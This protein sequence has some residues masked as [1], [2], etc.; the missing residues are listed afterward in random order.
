MPREYYII[1]MEF[2]DYLYNV[3]SIFNCLIATDG[4][5][6]ARQFYLFV[7]RSVSMN[8]CEINLKSQHSFHPS[9]LTKEYHKYEFMGKLLV[10]F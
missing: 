9:F 6:L 10:G 1:I 5:A 8:Y 2:I 7:H 3:E 4:M